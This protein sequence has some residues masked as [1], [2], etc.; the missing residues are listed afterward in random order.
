MRGGSATSGQTGDKPPASGQAGAGCFY[1]N[2]FDTP[3]SMLAGLCCGKANA[4][5]EHKQGAAF[6]AP[7]HAGNSMVVFN[8]NALG[9]LTARENSQHFPRRR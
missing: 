7:Q 6:S 1:L 4:T 8:H 2:H 9:N 3:A 5:G